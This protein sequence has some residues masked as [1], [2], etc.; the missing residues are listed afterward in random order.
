M[1]DVLVGVLALIVGLGVAFVGYRALRVVIALLG[2]AFG[3]SVGG[4]LAASIPAQGSFGTM[5]TWIGAIVGALLFGWLAYAFYQVA[6]LLGLAS[7][8]FAIGS[9]LMV[10]IGFRGGWLTWMVGAAVAVILV[11][12]G[13]IG[14]LPAVLLI[15]LTGLSGANIAVTGVMLLVGAVNMA[16]LTAAGEAVHVG[17]WWAVASVVLAVVAIVSQLGSLNRTKATAMRAQWA[18]P[19]R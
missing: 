8:G 18:Q 11:L 5:L 17:W 6:V 3:F 7:I 15:M 9:G 14:D 2:A 1:N 19:V 4:A 10:A 12:I 13:M 16:D